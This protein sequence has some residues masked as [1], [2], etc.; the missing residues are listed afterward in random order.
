MDRTDGAPD[1]GVGRADFGVLLTM[2]SAVFVDELARH[3]GAAG[4]D[5]FTARTGWVLRSVGDAQVPLKDLAERMRLSS[6]GALKAIAPMV[7]GGYLERVGAYDRRV[8]AVAAT[9]LGREA[10]EEARVFHAKFEAGLVEGVG[11]ESVEA[12]RAALELLVARGAREVTGAIA[13]FPG[14]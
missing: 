6:P 4:Y 13:P 9:D 11:A 7:E 8:R 1:G 10:L 2:S 5:G 12:V 3:M 14:S